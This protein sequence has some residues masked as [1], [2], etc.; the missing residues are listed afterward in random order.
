MSVKQIESLLEQN[1]DF[2]ISQTFR[3]PFVDFKI[4]H[5]GETFEK[6]I[7]SEPFIPSL[8]TLFY[9]FMENHSYQFQSQNVNEAAIY[10]RVARMWASLI[11]E[12]HAYYLL[13]DIGRKY[14]LDETVII[15][16]DELDTKKGIDIYLFNERNTSESIKLDILQSTKRA[17]YFRNKKDVLRVK[18]K[19]IPGKKY[20]ILLGDSEPETTKVINN[21]F[22]L[23]NNYG[24]KVIKDFI[25]VLEQ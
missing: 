16:N 5:V 8:K 9:K 13:L 23:N 17:S 3:H 10:G 25:Q 6:L 20:R 2:R 24:D 14:D 18:D 21:W 4:S 19:E 15:R 22:L 11:R 7:N 1:N 12:W